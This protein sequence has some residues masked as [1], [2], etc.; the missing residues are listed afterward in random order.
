MSIATLIPAWLAVLVPVA[1]A[2]WQKSGDARLPRKPG[3]VEGHDNTVVND[4]RTIVGSGN[5]IIGPTND[6]GN[7]IINGGSIAIGRGATAGPGSI[8]IGAGARA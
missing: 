1:V 2:V 6:R 7:T 5:T 3:G 8:A 4:D